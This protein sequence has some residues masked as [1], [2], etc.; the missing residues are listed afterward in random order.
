MG[1]IEACV[2]VIGATMVVAI[3]L[4]SM[5]IFDLVYHMITQLNANAINTSTSSSQ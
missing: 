4:Y 3:V 5:G 2:W 1:K